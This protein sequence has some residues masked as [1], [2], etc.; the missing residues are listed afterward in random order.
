MQVRRLLSVEVTR[1]KLASGTVAPGAFRP[2]RDRPGTRASGR[3]PKFKLTQHRHEKAG[4]DG[5]ALKPSARRA[6]SVVG[7]NGLGGEADE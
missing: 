7:V 3:K 6:R 5:L 2:H 4:R 1:S